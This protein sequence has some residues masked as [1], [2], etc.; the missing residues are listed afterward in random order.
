MAKNDCERKTVDACQA[1]LNESAQLLRANRLM[2][3]ECNAMLKAII[4]HMEVPYKPPMGFMKDEPPNGQ[5]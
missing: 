1:A 2:L 5:E 4:K 3:L